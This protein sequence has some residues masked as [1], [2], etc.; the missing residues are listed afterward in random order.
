MM[1]D[2]SLTAFLNLT[3]EEAVIIIPKLTPQARLSYE[4]M[5]SVEIVSATNIPDSTPLTQTREAQ[6]E[7]P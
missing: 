3:D 2:E 6:N 5:A 7:T 1:D 4:R